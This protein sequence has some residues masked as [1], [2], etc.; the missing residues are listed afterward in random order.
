MALGKA[1]VA[2]E[3]RE[4]SLDYPASG[5]DPEAFASI[6]LHNDRH[7]PLALADLAQCLPELITSTTGGEL[8]HQRDRI[9]DFRQR[10]RRTNPVLAIGFMD[11]GMK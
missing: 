7:R 3:P 4:A 8:P 10:E 2:T 5:Q 11:H 1:P 6:G 9:D